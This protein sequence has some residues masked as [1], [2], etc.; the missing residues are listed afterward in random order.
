[1]TF[2][3]SNWLMSIVIA[4]QPHFKRQTKAETIFWGYALHTNTDGDYIKKPI[5]DCTGEEILIELLHHLH[6]ENEKDDIMNDVINVIPCMMPY[7]ISMFQPRAIKDRPQVVPLGSTNFAMISQFV[8]IPGDM[9]FTEEYSVRAAR[10]AVYKL[11]KI[12][13][14]I[15]PI[16][17][18]YKNMRTKIKAIATSYR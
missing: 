1:M 7:I 17:P 5:R 4:A 8:E 9:V 2:K 6:F 10:I 18:H 14:E 12:D 13:K 11:M 16:T 15:C 3:D